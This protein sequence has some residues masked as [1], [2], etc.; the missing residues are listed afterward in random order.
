M[1]HG[2]ISAVVAALKPAKWI[3]LIGLTY[4]VGG[5]IIMADCTQSMCIS[6]L[7]V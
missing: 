7:N 3:T 5:D 1:S 6:S 2:K 4:S